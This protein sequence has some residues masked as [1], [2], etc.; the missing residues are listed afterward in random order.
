MVGSNSYTEARGP[1]L[2]AFLRFNA[3]VMDAMSSRATGTFRALDFF[4]ALQKGMP[5][6]E[7]L[8]KDG[9]WICFDMF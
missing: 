9:V 7:I 4:Q 3:R 5:K 6:R 1:L 8:D 2:D